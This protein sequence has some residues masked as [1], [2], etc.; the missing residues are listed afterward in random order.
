MAELSALSAAATVLDL[1]GATSRTFASNLSSAWFFLESYGIAGPILWL[2]G[3]RDVW[4]IQV[5]VLQ[6]TNESD[7]MEFKKLAQNDSNIIAVAGT[8]VAQIAITALSLTDLSST[9]WVARASFTFSLVSAIMAVYYATNQY[10]R[11]GRFLHADEIKAWI[12]PKETMRLSPRPLLQQFLPS[13]ASVLTV[14]APNMLLSAS[15]NAF[16]VGLGVYFGYVWTRNLDESAGSSASRAVF[17]VYVIGLALCYVIYAMS[18][19]VAADQSQISEWN[20][21]RGL[22][23]STARARDQSSRRASNPDLEAVTENCGP[24]SK[25]E[26]QPRRTE[27]PEDN[28]SRQQLV[29]A[30]REAADLRR[31]SAVA[32]E[33]VARLLE[34]LE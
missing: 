25:I 10:R 30:L 1:I 6:S 13:A 11:F 32:D 20:F 28:S 27:N 8:I 3:D 22:H 26:E 34:N 33:R 29:K 17:I 24:S 23:S 31:R 15:L 2:Y 16:L 4:R 12:R 7:A 5:Q 18:D 9:H 14:S 21:I 19:L